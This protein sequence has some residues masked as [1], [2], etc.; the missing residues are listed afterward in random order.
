MCVPQFSPYR[1][2]S[3]ETS[4][5]F[6]NKFPFKQEN[7]ATQTDAATK[8]MPVTTRHP[9]TMLSVKRSVQ[10]FKKQW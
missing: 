5:E 6:K 1:Q 8:P 10:N 9:T 3:L 4:L 2:Q 7:T